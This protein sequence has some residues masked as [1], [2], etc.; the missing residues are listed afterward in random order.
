MGGVERRVVDGVVVGKTEGKKTLG[1]P[2][3]RW[4]DNNEGLK[5]V[6]W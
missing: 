2:R 1:R 5:E 6:S 4:E 3:H